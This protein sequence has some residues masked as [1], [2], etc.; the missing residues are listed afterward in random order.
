[1]TKQEFKT[2]I[3]SCSD[4]EFTSY[5]LGINVNGTLL[6]QLLLERRTNNNIPIP[7]FKVGDRVRLLSDSEDNCPMVITELAIQNPELQFVGFGF[8]CFKKVHCAW[9]DKNDMPHDQWYDE[10]VLCKVQ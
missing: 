10:D 4:D 8:E 7:F 3:N 6:G 5:L 1:M 9:R 2:F